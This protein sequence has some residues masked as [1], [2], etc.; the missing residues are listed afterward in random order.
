MLSFI[1]KKI[2][3]LTYLCVQRKIWHGHDELE[4]EREVMLL[5]LDPSLL[6]LLAN[7]GFHGFHLV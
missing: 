3:E 4:S 2:F 7:K 6:D 5:D 1:R